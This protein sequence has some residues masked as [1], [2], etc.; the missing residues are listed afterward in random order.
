MYLT[1]IRNKK[2]ITK[3]CINLYIQLAKIDNQY[4]NEKNPDER[5]A[6]QE[7]CIGF[8]RLE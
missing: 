2:V 4:P 6:V 8:E 5:S 1:Q 3:V 7:K